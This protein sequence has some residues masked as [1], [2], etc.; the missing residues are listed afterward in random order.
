MPGF[1]ITMLPDAVVQAYTLQEGRDC[2]AVSLYVTLDEPR[3]RCAPVETRLERVPIV[4]QP[5]PRPARHGGHRGLAER[6]DVLPS[7]CAL[8][9]IATRRGQ[10][11]FL[12]QL[13][14]QT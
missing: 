9:P 10:L 1:K 8:S 3:W 2:P 14:C 5:A 6:P 7:K 13:A 12:Y 11:S 4:R